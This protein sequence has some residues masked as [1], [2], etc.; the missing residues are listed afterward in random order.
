MLIESWC[1]F[2]ISRLHAKGNV[3][4]REIHCWGTVKVLWDDEI[5]SDR[6]LDIWSWDIAEDSAIAQAYPIAFSFFPFC[7]LARTPG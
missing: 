1:V 6:S 5:R 7:L 4:Y 2:D 3:S